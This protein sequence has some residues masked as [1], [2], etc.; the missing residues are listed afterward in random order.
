MPNGLS[1]FLFQI[2]LQKSFC[3]VLCGILLRSMFELNL[4]FCPKSN[5]LEVDTDHMYTR[6]GGNVFGSVPLIAKIAWRIL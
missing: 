2:T 5:L 3:Y 4:Y 6:E 1:N